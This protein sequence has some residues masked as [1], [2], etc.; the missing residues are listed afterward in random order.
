MTRTDSGSEVIIRIAGMASLTPA[1]FLASV[2]ALVRNAF[3][4]Q[5][6]ARIAKTYSGAATPYPNDPTP[7]AYPNHHN[8]PHYL[9]RRVTVS[10]QV[11]L[12]I[13]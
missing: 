3:L 5:P 9:G 12:R 13:L 2:L 10:L 4:P 1:D 7:L 11:V 8:D 6:S